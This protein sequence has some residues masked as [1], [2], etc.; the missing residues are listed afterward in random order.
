MKDCVD[1]SKTD[2]TIT[3]LLIEFDEMGFAPTTV[4]PNAEQCAIDWRD[5]VRKEFARLITE[6]AALR[7]RIENAVE[8][9]CKVGD[10][11][12]SIFEFPNEKAIFITP[13]GETIRGIEVF[14][15]EDVPKATGVGYIP[16]WATCPAANDF[17]RKVKNT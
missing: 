3:D 10:T 14:Q 5:R 8:L 9:P 11:V 15:P 1:A 7:K 12:Y 4:C 6:N 2:Q 16:H 17:R 13:N